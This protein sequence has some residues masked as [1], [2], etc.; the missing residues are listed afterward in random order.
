[1]LYSDIS[2]IKLCPAASQL[3]LDVKNL[4]ANAGDEEIASLWLNTVRFLISEEE[5]LASGS[6]TRLDHSRAFVWQTFIKVQKG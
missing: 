2:L 5:D 3:V 4:P 6:W 1:M